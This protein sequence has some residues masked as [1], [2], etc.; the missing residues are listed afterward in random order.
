VFIFTIPDEEWTTND[1]PYKTIFD[2]THVIIHFPPDTIIHIEPTIPP[3]LNKDPRIETLAVRILY[4]HHKN[5]TIDIPNLE[6]KLLQ[7]TT[8][9][10]IN[11]QHVITPPPTPIN[12]K[13]HKR[14]KW[15]KSSHL[16]QPNPSIALQLPDFPHIHQPK[17]PPQYCYYTDGS[18]TPP[19]Q[20][21]NGFWNPAQ[22]GYGIWNPLL[23]INLPQR[24]IGLQNRLRAEMSTIHHTLQILIQEF[25]N[26]PTHIFTNSLNSLYLI[27]TQIKHPTQQN[28]HPDKTILASIVNML[29]SHTTT[30]HLYKVRTHTNIIGNKEANKFAK[31]GSKIVLVSDI[32]FQP[33]ESTHSTPY[34]W[35]REDDHPYRGPIRHLKSY[36]E[37]LEK[38]ENEKLDK[39]FDNITNGLIT[40]S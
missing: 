12:T 11:P 35:C 4:I 40:P 37:K 3:K 20:Q 2:E 26:E 33:H 27:N 16:P 30:T 32:P 24:L 38:E 34:W 23:K 25:P 7:A 5:T 8:K 6:S 28:N 19:K 9:L 14:P 36:L 10:R 13:V 29:K 21:A 31:E 22:A 17:F 1:A 18:F 15:N 39:T